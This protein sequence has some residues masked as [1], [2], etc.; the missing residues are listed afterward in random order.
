MCCVHCG[1]QLVSVY[2]NNWCGADGE[3]ADGSSSSGGGGEYNTLPPHYQR[4][5]RCLHHEQQQQQHATCLGHY[6][7]VAG[8][9]QRAQL[10]YESV[11]RDHG[12]YGPTATLCSRHGRSNSLSPGRARYY[13]TG[14]QLCSAA[15]LRR[16][17]MAPPPGSESAALASE[18]ASAVEEGAAATSSATGS[19]ARRDDVERS[20]RYA[21]DEAAAAA[22][23]A[24]RRGVSATDNRE[25]CAA[26]ASELDNANCQL[27]DEVPVPDAADD[28]NRSEQPADTARRKT[29]DALGD[30]SCVLPTDA[31]RGIENGGNLSEVLDA[32]TDTEERNVDVSNDVGAPNQ[33]E[34]A[35]IKDDHHILTDGNVDGV[36]PVAGALAEGSQLKLS[37]ERA[38]KDGGG[39]RSS[40]SPTVISFDQADTTSSGK[41][42][43]SALEKFLNSLSARRD[44]DRVTTNDCADSRDNVD[45]DDVD[46]KV[47]MRGDVGVCESSL[48]MLDAPAASA[49]LD[50]ELHVKSRRRSSS[51]SSSS[52]LSVGHCSPSCLI[53]SSTVDAD[54]DVATSLF[55]SAVNTV[56]SSTLATTASLA[57]TSTVPSTS[58]GVELA[59]VEQSSSTSG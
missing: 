11:S 35:A 26:A 18:A 55:F 16:P 19:P 41:F 44:R 23:A 40:E 38:E 53:P 10:M 47:W 45:D 8:A 27:G 3:Q 42:D 32:K 29:S 28:A 34:V 33:D 22:D 37:S 1:V 59:A 43:S 12:L 6:H 51:S 20:E 48:S 58:A 25:L 15:R 57:A 14:G 21:D 9:Q 2:V 31:D 24:D 30:S 7:A 39:E 56:N 5:Q 17:L 52:S 50:D 4:Y 54:A 46:D 13:A 49:R 36:H